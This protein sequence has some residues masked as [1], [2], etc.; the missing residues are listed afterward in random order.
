MNGH[1]F[2]DHWYVHYFQTSLSSQR[3]E[4]QF[5]PVL[6]GGHLLL[7]R[8]SLPGAGYLPRLGLCCVLSPQHFPS[9]SA[10]QLPTFCCSSSLPTKEDS[11]PSSH[12][13]KPSPARRARGKQV[14]VWWQAG[15]WEE[16]SIGEGF[17][18]APARFI[19]TG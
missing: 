17:A 19:K 6:A 13:A 7:P 3:N 18:A 15:D 2:D 12:L 9:S 16:G 8:A 14:E 11:S 4:F 10:K 5:Q 1:L